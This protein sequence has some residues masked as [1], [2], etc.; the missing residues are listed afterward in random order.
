MGLHVKKFSRLWRKD[1]KAIWVHNDLL[2][3]VSCWNRVCFF[4]TNMSQKNGVKKIN[5]SCNSFEVS[6]YYC[7]L[8]QLALQDSNQKYSKTGDVLNFHFLTQNLLLLSAHF[9]VQ[10]HSLPRQMWVK[11]ILKQLTFHNTALFLN[12]K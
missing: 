7:F 10:G 6:L 3:A 5:T 8:T 1:C 12:Q 9:S 2:C 4:G 11:F